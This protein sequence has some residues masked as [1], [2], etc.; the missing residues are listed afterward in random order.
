MTLV[1]STLQVAFFHG[2]ECGFFLGSRVWAF[3][4]YRGLGLRLAGLRVSTCK[5]V[6]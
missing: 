6:V 4:V 1:P 5:I 3:R 2:D